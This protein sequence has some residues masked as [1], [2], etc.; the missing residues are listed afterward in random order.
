MISEIT[1]TTARGKI[2]SAARILLVL[3]VIVVVAGMVAGYFAGMATSLSCFAVIFIIVILDIALAA[4][5]TRD[6]KAFDSLNF[7]LAADE[8]DAPVDL[9]R[10]RELVAATEQYLAQNRL[11]ARSRDTSSR[12]P[13][14]LESRS[15]A[16]VLGATGL[17]LHVLL[18]IRATQTIVFA[19]S[20]V[21]DEHDAVARKLLEGLR[22]E[23]LRFGENDRPESET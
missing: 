14:R 3:N 2:G 13:G 15:T 12:W 10:Y 9:A 5:F 1:H 23:L 18:R 7:Q 4:A 11:S 16:F 22:Q 8:G 6:R 17:T 21:A 20:P 19:L